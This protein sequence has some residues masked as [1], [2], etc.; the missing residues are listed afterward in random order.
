MS[1]FG[2]TGVPSL[3]PRRPEIGGG[4][5]TKILRGG[6]GA[7]VVLAFVLCQENVALAGATGQLTGRVVDASSNAPIAGANITAVSPTG[8]YKA[9]TSS[10]GYYAIVNV[11]PDTYR[12]TVSAEGYTSAMSDGNTVN[13]NVST[14]VD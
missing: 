3:K 1:L 6:L 11:Y 8:T 14:A 2:I 13:Q 10:N 5:F 7:A 12:V 9:V 4:M